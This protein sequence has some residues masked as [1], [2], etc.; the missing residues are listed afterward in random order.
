MTTDAP[1]TAPARSRTRA[2]K[3]GPKADAPETTP[4]LPAVPSGHLRVFVH[5]TV[6]SVAIG[7]HTV[8]STD[9]DCLDTGDERTWSF[10]APA[11]EAKA[12]VDAYEFAA[13][14][15]GG[16]PLTHDEDLAAKDLAA[17]SNVE[18]SRMASA[19]AEIAR[20]RVA[21]V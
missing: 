19:L 14:N 3:A 15:S 20:D 5:D 16:V 13:F 12:L 4:A 21:G 17:R 18:V 10:T 6:S 1:E 7:E 9:D 8:N 11:D 2:R